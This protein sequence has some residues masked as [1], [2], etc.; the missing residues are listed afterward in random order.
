MNVL[1]EASLVLFMMADNIDINAGT[2]VDGQ[3]TVQD[4]GQ[5]IY[6]TIR[7][8][9]SGERTKSEMLG[10]KEFVLWLIGPVLLHQFLLRCQ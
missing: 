2:I 5:N 3:A 7:R 9:A 4:V 8:G 10:H 6:E 1:H